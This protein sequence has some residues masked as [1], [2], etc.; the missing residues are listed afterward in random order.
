MQYIEYVKTKMF[1]ND[2]TKNDSE[3]LKH[4]LSDKSFKPQ[5][6]WEEVFK[7]LSLNPTN[8]FFPEGRK[9]LPLQE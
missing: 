1:M 8:D 6:S 3:E 5:K 7:E 9:D 2:Q 4:L